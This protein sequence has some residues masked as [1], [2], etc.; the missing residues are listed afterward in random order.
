[1][2]WNRAA[3]FIMATAAFGAPVPAPK[4][5]RIAVRYGSTQVLIVGEDIYTDDVA[6]AS[7][8]T[9]VYDRYPKLRRT[10]EIPFVSAVPP[11]LLQSFRLKPRT[12]WRIG[13][14]WQLYPG[15][16]PSVTVVIETV[17]I[18]S[19]GC[20]GFRDGAIASFL[21]PTNAN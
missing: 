3:V 12:D 1:M 16:G 19:S 15:A 20:G 11:S 8:L 7:I 18:L 2:S 4:G 21:I 10:D 5:A 17:V 9:T 6:T 14:Q 13:T